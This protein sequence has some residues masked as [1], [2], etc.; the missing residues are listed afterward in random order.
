MHSKPQADVVSCQY[1]RYVYP[2]PI[3]DLPLWLQDNWQ[4]Y[5]PSHA[6]QIFWPD[7]DYCPK[8]DILVA[9]CGSNQAAVIAY[10]NP[11]SKVIAI[12]VSQ[13]AL[14]HHEFLRDKYGLSNLELY[15][16]D[17][18][19]V[20][21]IGQS[22]DLVICTGVLHHMVEPERGLK[23]LGGCLRPKGVAAIMVY[24]RFGRIG[25]EMLQGV[26]RELGLGQNEASVLMVKEA[27]SVLPKDHP[28]RTYMESANDL[29]F[30]A[31]L[32]DTFL[33][34]RECSYTVYDCI[35]LVKASGLIFQDLFFHA[36]YSPPSYSNNAFFT[37]ISALP[38]QQRWSLMERINYR[39]GCH[40]F[41]ARRSSLSSEHYHLDFNSTDSREYIPSWRFR[42]SLNGNQAV[43]PR[44]S[45]H[46]D[47][48][49]LAILQQVN[50]ELAI[51][52]IA[53]EAIKSGV[54]PRWEENELERLVLEVIHSF[55]QLDIL[56]IRMNTQAN[57]KVHQDDI[58]P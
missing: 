26:F 52:V 10:T 17:I 31:G 58:D 15:H 32:V 57:A 30:D 6:Y 5:D 1:E 37:V 11:N 34:G 25:V 33:H 47:A 24:A 48:I 50:G 19:S 43:S 36:P 20:G 7:R 14:K 56:V 27:L 23:A 45:K 9:G 53:R 38:D 16:L 29:Q 55:W 21:Q 51:R 22:F 54:L 40:F 42:C 35:A 44:G 12:D 4:W 8:L 46:L 2:D 41:L 3:I 39:N 13:S 49:E 18:E 28:V